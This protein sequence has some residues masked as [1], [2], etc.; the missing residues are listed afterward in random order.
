MMNCGGIGPQKT[1]DCGFCSAANVA[2]AKA[3]APAAT[4]MPLLCESIPTKFFA[5]PWSPPAA[6]ADAPGRVEAR[7][8]EPRGKRKGPRGLGEALRFKVRTPIG[9]ALHARLRG[10]HRRRQDWRAAALPDRAAAEA[11]V[12]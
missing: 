6:A 7:L 5:R 4:P 9:S 3:R 12:R 10:R 1:K 2:P 8:P 11:A